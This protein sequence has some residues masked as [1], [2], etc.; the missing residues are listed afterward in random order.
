VNDAGSRTEPELSIPIAPTQR[1]S[2]TAAAQPLLEPPASRVLP[3]GFSVY[4]LN[5]DFENRDNPR[6]AMV[7]V[8]RTIAPAAR[9][10]LTAGASASARRGRTTR[11]PNAVGTS[12]LSN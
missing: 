8:A 7:A 2:A 6:S 12:T 5:D 3:Y 11:D 1:L 4:P 10:R 9:N